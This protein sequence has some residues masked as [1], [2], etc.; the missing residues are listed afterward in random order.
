M[1]HPQL[2]GG[3]RVGHPPHLLL[4][5]SPIYTKPLDW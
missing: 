3:P 1:G 5:P 2:M 4:H